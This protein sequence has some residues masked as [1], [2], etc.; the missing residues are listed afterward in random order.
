MIKNYLRIRKHEI[1]IIIIKR[2]YLKQL[3]DIQYYYE[4]KY[5]IKYIKY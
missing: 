4:L 3:R 1:L 2:D 5:M